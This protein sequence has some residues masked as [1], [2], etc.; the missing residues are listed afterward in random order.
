MFTLS[1]SKN[2]VSSGGV[3]VGKSEITKITRIQTLHFRY[4]E[5]LASEAAASSKLELVN[6]ENDRLRKQI[7]EITTEK[8]NLIIERQGLQTQCR[9]A[10]MKWDEIEKELHRV[11]SDRDNFKKGFNQ[12]MTDNLKV[13]FM[14][15]KLVSDSLSINSKCPSL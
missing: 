2:I 7:K 4:G 5:V 3:Q 15:I 11:R 6:E 14:Q 8:N 10:I 12:A 13:T 9:T 1:E